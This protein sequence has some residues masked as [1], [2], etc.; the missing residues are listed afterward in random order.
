MNDLNKTMTELANLRLPELQAKYAEVVGKKTRAPNKKF[1]LRKIREALAAGG[2]TTTTNGHDP[3]KILAT[4][5]TL[6]NQKEFEEKFEDARQA[7]P[8]LKP[9]PKPPTTIAVRD[10]QSC[11][12]MEAEAFSCTLVINGQPAADVQNAG[13]GGCFRFDFTRS[14]GKMS[15]GPMFELYRKY[16]EAL[17]AEPLDPNRP[18]EGMMKPNF[19]M[20]LESAIE[21]QA[22]PK[23]PS[24]RGTSKK[25]SDKEQKVL[26]MRFPKRVVDAIDEAWQ[27][28]GKKNR[29]EMIREAFAMWLRS[30]GEDA[31][32]ELLA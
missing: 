6:K 17:P 22:T 2:E 23:R 20:A 16:V 18:G 9:R 13:R 14:D 27:R 8:R 10:F 15:G 7:P 3:K 32:A 28:Q 26:A 4:L 25:A 11:R 19:D 24:P 21:A 5:A 30:H 12:G 29:M 31:T 1:L